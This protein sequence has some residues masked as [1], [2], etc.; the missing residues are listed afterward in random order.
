MR[1]QGAYIFAL[2]V[3]SVDVRTTWAVSDALASLLADVEV[4]TLT[5][6]MQPPSEARGSIGQPGGGK[7][8]GPSRA[9]AQKAYESASVAE[10]A[11]SKIGRRAK[12]Q[13]A[14]RRRLD[15]DSWEGTYNHAVLEGAVGQEGS[16]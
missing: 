10:H 14:G 8:P 12:S 1:A 9:A 11:K 15:E 16:E 7:G 6:N 4:D 2:I 5:A 3:V 13:D